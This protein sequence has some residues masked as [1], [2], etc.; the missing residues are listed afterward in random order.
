MQH[1]P[2]ATD[3]GRPVRATPDWR[4]DPEGVVPPRAP[5]RRR[6]SGPAARRPLALVVEDDPDA[7]TVAVSMLRILGFE[8]RQAM[9]AQQALSALSTSKP[10]LV[11]RQLQEGE[12]PADDPGRGGAQQAPASLPSRRGPGGAACRVG[13]TV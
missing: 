13:A 9:D 1:T 8:T 5:S 11:V 6:R 12:D 10:D 3:A 2:P 4:T 7:S